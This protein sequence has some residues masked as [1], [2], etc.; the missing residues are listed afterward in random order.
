[1]LPDA[2]AAAGGECERH[3]HT[4]LKSCGP[5]HF[6]ESVLSNCSFIEQPV[7]ASNIKKNVLVR[8]IC[9]RSAFEVTIEEVL[10][11]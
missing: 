10:L 9:K 6:L 2:A 5:T 11:K 4:H 1:M 7:K 3:E 8:F